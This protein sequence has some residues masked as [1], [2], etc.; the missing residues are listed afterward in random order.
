MQPVNRPPTRSTSFPKLSAG[1][2]PVPYGIGQGGEP[3]RGVGLFILPAGGRPQRDCLAT[4]TPLSVLKHCRLTAF[5]TKP[6]FRPSINRVTLIN[7]WLG[8]RPRL[9]GRKDFDTKLSGSL[10][11]PIAERFT[12]GAGAYPNSEGVSRRRSSDNPDDHCWPSGLAKITPLISTGM[13]AVIL[14]RFNHRIRIET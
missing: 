5:V 14:L 2:G 10:Q 1:Q 13:A 6:P 7:E 9:G 8:A 12:E 4:L 11:A 3:P